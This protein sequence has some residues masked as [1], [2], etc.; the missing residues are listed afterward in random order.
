MRI[1]SVRSFFTENSTEVPS[2]DGERI[3]LGGRDSACLSAAQSSN[4]FNYGG[5]FLSIF[6]LLLCLSFAVKDAVGK[7]LAA[8]LFSLLKRASISFA[9]QH[10]V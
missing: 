1:P 4:H 5:L 3:G 10:L 9:Q 6:L 8:L 7:F 2:Y